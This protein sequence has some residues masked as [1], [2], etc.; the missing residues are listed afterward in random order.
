[1]FII[2]VIEQ[3]LSQEM[4][5][6]LTFWSQSRWCGI[7]KSNAAILFRRDCRPTSIS[8]FSAVSV[9]NFMI[10]PQDKRNIKLICR[11]PWRIYVIKVWILQTPH[12]FGSC[13]LPQKDDGVCF[14]IW[15]RY[16]EQLRSPLTFVKC[17]DWRTPLHKLPQNQSGY[18]TS[19]NVM[20]TSSIRLA[21]TSVAL[22]LVQHTPSGGQR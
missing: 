1:M 8:I 3:K 7:V 12:G 17:F 21:P 9:D 5:L 4:E 16:A 13:I 19:R 14:R 18:R 2:S 22:R 20:R 11:S 6:K 15:P 10:I